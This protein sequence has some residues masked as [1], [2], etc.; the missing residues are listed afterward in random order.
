M[1]P[2]RA[3]SKTQARDTVSGQGCVAHHAG[4]MHRDIPA[5]S[6]PH[7]LSKSSLV[8]GYA[9]LALA[10]DIQEQPPGLWQRIQNGAHRLADFQAR[11]LLTIIYG[12]FVL[13]V[14]L[15]VRLTEDAL[16]LRIR[17]GHSTYWRTWRGNSAT[18]DQTRRQG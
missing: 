5:P 8:A 2:E 14:G 1:P 13:P 7:I 6:A 18:L 10:M 17:R 3:Q 16:G 9:I 12:L 11:I 15:I 4:T